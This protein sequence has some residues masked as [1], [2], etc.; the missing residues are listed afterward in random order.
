MANTSI[1]KVEGVVRKEFKIERSP[2]RDVPI[3][4]L[5]NDFNE[6]YIALAQNLRILPSGKLDP[7]QVKIDP[8]RASWLVFPIEGGKTI[9]YMDVFNSN[10][11][12]LIVK[13]TDHIRDVNQDTTA[14]DNMNKMITVNMEREALKLTNFEK[15]TVTMS[16]KG[17]ADV[18][19]ASAAP[20]EASKPAAKPINFTDPAVRNMLANIRTPAGKSLL[21]SIGKSE[22]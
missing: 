6:K 9:T 3:S 5:K 20:A 14:L 8:A 12:E 17:A 18:E 22:V 16:P 7:K 1:N 15:I 21:E 4:T 13:I 10:D 2:M 11:P 19:I